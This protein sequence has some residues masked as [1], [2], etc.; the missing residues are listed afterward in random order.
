MDSTP[1]IGITDDMHDTGW[2]D[3]ALAPVLSLELSPEDE[4]EIER[5]VAYATMRKDAK[6][7]PQR[8]RE[9]NASGL[10]KKISIRIARSLLDLLKEQ[11]A[12]LG[13]PYQTYMNLLLHD[14][15]TR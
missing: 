5:F 12:I 3:D 9:D 4:A 11:A 10:S 13:I 1:D 7:K 15:A 6:P 14:A 2:L 8:K